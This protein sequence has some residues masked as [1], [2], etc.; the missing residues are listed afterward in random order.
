MKKLCDLI[1]KVCFLEV[2]RNF[3]RFW[4]CLAGLVRVS[5]GLPESSLTPSNALQKLC[6]IVGKRFFFLRGNFLRLL[7]GSVQPNFNYRL[8][9]CVP[10]RVETE[11]GISKQLRQP[12]KPSRGTR[13][14]RESTNWWSFGKLSK[15]PKKALESPLSK[16]FKPKIWNFKLWNLKF[17]FPQ[18]FSVLA[19]NQCTAADKCAQNLH[20]QIYPLENSS[21][22]ARAA[23]CF[24]INWFLI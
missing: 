19:S 16:S 22:S 7:E 21:R 6:R 12:G 9:Y 8:F 4:K 11:F 2:F 15:P 10:Q 3:L 20:Y 1:I 17:R 5:S 23:P 14:L 13:E 18:Q 24:W